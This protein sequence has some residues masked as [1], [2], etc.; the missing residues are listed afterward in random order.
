MPKIDRVVVASLRRNA[1]ED[2]ELSLLDL[3]GGPRFELRRMFKPTA[4]EPRPMAHAE[5]LS[6]ATWHLPAL[7]KAF[8]EAE[9]KARELGLLAPGGEPVKHRVPDRVPKSRKRAA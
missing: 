2:I 8:A 3:D 1:R 6:V 9:A 4:G 7:A 5:V